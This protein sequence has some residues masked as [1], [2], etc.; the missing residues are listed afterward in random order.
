VVSHREVGSNR[1]Y[2]GFS[3]ILKM[4]M[5]LRQASMEAEVKAAAEAQRWILPGQ[6]IRPGPFS[7]TGRIEDPPVRA[8]AE[9]G[10]GG[11][12]SRVVR[13]HPSRLGQEQRAG[14]E[15]ERT[16][17]V[18]VPGHGIRNGAVSV[19]PGANRPPGC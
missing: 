15:A 6:E 18:D 12:H 4:D 9:E 1:V 5:E 10:Q 17:N 16:A 19:S 7:C 8:L 2:G 13:G 3:N 14:I 11:A